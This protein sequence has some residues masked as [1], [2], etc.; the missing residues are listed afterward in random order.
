AQEQASQGPEKERTVPLRS[1]DRFE[2][3]SETVDGFW[4]E[5][6]GLYQESNLDNAAAH[7]T[8]GKYDAHGA[9]TF[10][11][12]AYGRDNKWEGNVFIPFYSIDADF[13]T[14]GMKDD[15]DDG[16]GIGDITL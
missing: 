5:V 13:K 9:T 8:T 6:G 2:L 4:A 1:F 3:E 7:G 12:A 14:A 16:S 15:L 11:R 10:A